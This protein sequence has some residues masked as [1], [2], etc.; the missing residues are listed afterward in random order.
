MVRI[1][2]IIGV[3]L[4]LIITACQALPTPAPTATATI[5]PGPSPTPTFTPTAMP[6]PT[7]VPVVRIDAGDTALF[8]GDYDLAREQYRTAF[9]DTTDNAIKAAALWGIGRTDLAD[10]RYQESLDAL[11]NLVNN[12]SDSTYAARAYFLIGE[13]YNGLEQYQPTA[14]AY[15]TYMTRIPGVRDGYVQEPFVIAHILI[16]LEPRL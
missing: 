7:P 13:D 5:T 3:W 2:K 12:Y 4:L 16:T 9:N 6:L 1:K 10:R 14:D 15:N 11:N 8:N